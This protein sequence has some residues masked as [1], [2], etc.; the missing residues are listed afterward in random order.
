MESVGS[1]GRDGIGA[2]VG[3]TVPVGRLRWLMRE[4]AEAGVAV[5]VTLDS[6]RANAPFG[7]EA[8]R[9]RQLLVILTR[10]CEAI[11]G[12]QLLIILIRS[13]GQAGFCL[14]KKLT[15]QAVQRSQN[16][17]AAPC[18]DSVGLL[19]ELGGRL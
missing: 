7:C 9:G 18:V 2:V 11:R 17:Y 12:R 14:V 16:D 5:A 19:Q 13:G 1:V 3:Y 8:I 4:F 15:K 10:S 6:G